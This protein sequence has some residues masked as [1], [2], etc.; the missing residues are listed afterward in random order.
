MYFRTASSLAGLDAAPE[1]LVVVAA[2]SAANGGWRY[3]PPAVAGA[4][5]SGFQYLDDVAVAEG[6]IVRDNAFARMRFALIPS[7][8]GNESPELVTTSLQTSCRDNQ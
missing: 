3:G 4:M 2:I 7:S 6:D 8:D 5:Q 1:R